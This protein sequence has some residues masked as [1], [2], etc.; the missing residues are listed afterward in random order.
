MDE[1]T[2]ET[3]E[4]EKGHERRFVESEGSLAVLKQHLPTF[5]E[6]IF[7][8][9]PKQSTNPFKK[10]IVRNP[11]ESHRDELPIAAVSPTYRLV[12][13]Q[14]V[15]QECCDGLKDSG[16][17]PDGLH[18]SL[19]LSD[20][21]EMMEFKILLPE[22]FNFV[23]S[24][25]HPLTLQVECF[26]SVDESC[27]LMVLMGWYRFVCGNG[28]I[29]GHSRVEFRNRHSRGLDLRPI[30]KILSQS[31]AEISRDLDRIKEW[32]VTEIRTDRLISWVD[33]VLA[34]RWNVSSAA[35][36][37]NICRT[38]EDGEL[39]SKNQRLLASE[40]VFSRTNRVPGARFPVSNVFD[41]AQAMSWIASR[42]KHPE[43]RIEWQ[44]EIPHLLDDLCKGRSSS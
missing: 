42:R 4:F 5:R 33:H 39:E 38:G 26:N 29:I 7:R 3:S 6:A 31:L 20:F 25:G 22:T 24:D 23:P 44:L 15:I 16:I 14:E 2:F 21:G 13:H 10:L 37:L 8:M 40:R 35:R 1:F 18:C 12:Q 11:D 36:V 17:D 30:R 41:V 43:E 19:I 28:L 32:E 34:K 27:R 9:G